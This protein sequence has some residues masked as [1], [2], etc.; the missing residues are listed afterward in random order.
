MAGACT[1]TNALE[2]PKPADCVVVGAG[3]GGL[4]AAV[5]LARYLRDV[6]VLDDERSRALWIPRSHNCPGYPQGIPGPEL[7]ERLRRQAER[8]GAWL[9]QE[10]VEALEH[11]DDGSFVVEC[12][13][14][15]IIARSALLA[16]GAEDVQAPIADLRSAIQR[17]IVR[18]CP[19]CD[20][21]EVRDR[22]IAILGDGNC[23]LQEAMLLRSYTSDLTV[24]SLRRELETS[25]EERGQLRAVGVDLVDEP[26]AELVAEAEGVC[27]RL[28]SSDSVI[29]FD[30]IY[31]ALGLRARSELATRLGAEHDEDGMLI[32]DDHQRTSVPG[33]YAVG[34]VVA[35][36]AQIGV[37]MGQAAIAASTINSTLERRLR[38]SLIQAQAIMNAEHQNEHCSSG[39]DRQRS[40]LSPSNRAYADISGLSRNA[41]VRRRTGSKHFA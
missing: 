13:T 21:Y 11:A 28:A 16:T 26:V 25:D 23:R 9:R 12:G 30:T 29:R 27:A 22:R 18:H 6:V 41:D 32:V 39:S 33:L 10:R 17:G 7:L 19:T 4:T 24:L 40:L 3:P 34:D 35:G 37:A 14:K 1:R 38:P 5:Y 31:T 15:T 36:L 20:A 2:L 8:Y